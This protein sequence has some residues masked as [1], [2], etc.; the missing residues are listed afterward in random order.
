MK[1]N[2]TTN[3]NNIVT[4]SFILVC[5]IPSFLPC[6]LASFLSF[7]S[8]L[9]DIDIMFNLHST[10]Y[11]HLSIYIYIY[12]LLL[13]RRCFFWY[14]WMYVLICLYLSCSNCVEWDKSSKVMNTILNCKNTKIC[15]KD[16]KISVLSQHPAKCR[17]RHKTWNHTY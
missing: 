12:T 5:L 4:E 17:E 8:S 9:I 3:N 2:T 11:M 7:L 10:F 14:V 16:C 13:M 1:V 6:L 15:I